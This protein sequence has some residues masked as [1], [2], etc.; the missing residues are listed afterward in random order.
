MGVSFLES[1]GFSRVEYVKNI[2]RVVR[3]DI[4]KETADSSF[5]SRIIRSRKVNGDFRNRRRTA[6]LYEV[7][8][9]VLV[10]SFFFE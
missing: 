9:K 7:G 3:F 2:Y 6:H 10:P 8:G 5:R 4:G 1:H